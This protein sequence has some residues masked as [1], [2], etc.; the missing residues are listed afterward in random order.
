MSIDT[1]GQGRRGAH[2]EAS[3]LFLLSPWVSIRLRPRSIR[4]VLPALDAR[5]VSSGECQLR[6]QGLLTVGL[7]APGEEF[8]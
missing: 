1:P 2:G 6:G 3:G 5:S 4:M 7:L 8:V